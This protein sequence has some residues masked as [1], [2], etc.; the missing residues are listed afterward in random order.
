MYHS[1]ESVKAL[2]ILYHFQNGVYFDM[3][4]LLESILGFNFVQ[5]PVLRWFSRIW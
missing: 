1:I 3:I 4:S 5:A 2:Q